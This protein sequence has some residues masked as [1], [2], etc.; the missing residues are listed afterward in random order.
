[1][2][3]KTTL[4]LIVLAAAGGGWFLY[5]DTR[6]GARPAAADSSESLRLVARDL[7]QDRLSRIEI[8]RANDRILFVHGNGWSLDGGWPARSAEVR[9][10][11]DIVSGV[12]T[13]FEPIELASNNDLGQ[14]GLLREQNPVQVIATVTGDDSKETTHSLLFGQP[15]GGDGNPFTRPTFLRID[16]QSEILRL[17]PGTKAILNRPRDTYLK[18]QLFP[19]VERVKFDLP[20][21]AFPGEGETAAPIILLLVAKKIAVAGPDGAWTIDR[22][23]PKPVSP[24]AGAAPELSAEKLASQ[25]DMA[26]PV[27]DR[28][29]PGVLKSI[30][31]AI[32][33]LWVEQFVD[34]ADL[35]KTGL[36][37]PGWTVAV[38]F[39]DRP[40]VKVLIGAVSRTIERRPPA[41][42]ANPLAP[43]PPQPPAVREEYRYAK[44]P[45]NPQIFEVKTERFAELFVSTA[46]LR[47]PRI[48][49]FDPQAVRRI[50]VV[51]PS[52]RFVMTKTDDKWR[53]IEPWTAD[54]DAARI[55]E[56][57]DRLSALQAAGPDILDKADLPALGLSPGPGVPHVTLTL[58]DK[59]KPDDVE[60]R[61]LWIGKQDDTKKKVAV[62]AA[63]N[64]RVDL[65]GDDFLR[66]FDRPAVAYRGRRVLDVPASNLA[67]IGIERNNNRWT[68]SETGGAWTLTAGTEAPADAAKSSQLSAELCRLEAVD[69]VTD[70]P[71]PDD[72]ARFGLES[73]KLSATLTFRDGAAAKTLLIGGPREGKPE[74]YARWADSPLIFTIRSG[75]RDM[76]DQQP[77]NFRPLLVWQLTPESITQLDVQT[78]NE[79]FRLAQT[80]S[81][82]ALTAP[83]AATAS[84]A[85]VQPLLAAAATI[86]AERYEVAKSDDLAHYGLAKPAVRVSVATGAVNKS[87]AIGNAVPG[88]RS[89]F[90]K[91]SD[92][93]AVF[94]VSDALALAADRPVLTLIDRVLLNVNG[95]LVTEISGASSDGEWTLRKSGDQWLI[96]SL[97]PPQTADHLTIADLLRT[98]ADVTATRFVEFGPRAQF[99]RFGLDRPTATVTVLQA[100]TTGGAPQSHTLAIGLQDRD[101]EGFYARA[102]QSPGIAEIPA[103]TAKQLTHGDLDFVSR[104]LL[105]LDPNQLVAIR[106]RGGEELELART[107]DGWSVAKPAG[108]NADRANLDSL[109]RQLARLRVSRVVALDAT[110]PAKY[111]FDSS[112]TIVALVLKSPEGA[113]SEKTIEIGRPVAPRYNEPDGSRYVRLAGSAVVGILP[114]TIGNL[115]TAEPFKLRDRTIARFSEADRAVMERGFRKSVFVRQDGAWKMTEPVAADAEQ[116]PL[117]DLVTAASRLRADEF[118]ADRPAD[119]RKYGLDAPEAR[120]RFIANDRDVLKL[121]VGVKEANGDRRYAKLDGSDT[122]FLLDPAMSNRLVAE[123]RQ[124]NAWTAVPPDQIET[125]VY[126]I[127]DKTLVLQKADG[128]WQVPGR[129]EQAVNAAAIDDLAATMANLR[130]ERF[131]VDKDP[132][133][134]AFGLLNPARTIVIR[135]RGGNPLTLYLGGY[136]PGSKRLYARVFDNARTDVFTLSET[137]SAKLLRD[138]RDLLAK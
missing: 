52:E 91:L 101:S 38:E 120:W 136:E 44:L 3:W 20:R 95:P 32:P 112:G 60:T 48:L 25:W 26:A 69:F 85:A 14:F 34:V 64:P 55:N 11:V 45:D 90:A 119:L 123:Y 57:I 19:D 72:L 22:K 31:S 15:Q 110:D 63:G 83:Y 105:T 121:A 10:V 50:E 68:L 127:G 41:P 53:I 108:F 29:D 13:R 130:V 59:G 135:A 99:D 138:L 8:V 96:T 84:T 86:R 65:I 35:A 18:R 92:Q 116:T 62:Q 40:P 131:V 115:L 113:T 39:D 42:P 97:Q 5:R 82:W 126:S 128:R 87:I 122:V 49:R 21:P 56:F 47:D 78:E 125:L 43:P 80:P 137:D 77:L 37:K 24:R 66:I 133:L 16:A 61:T 93:D 89:R 70:A 17:A 132:D 67:S 23:G 118:V 46:A 114:P 81:G 54:A 36:E 100:S 106:R 51:R 4:A 58:A 27:S 74:V 12:S 117:N 73:A 111:G 134:R 129:P 109:V 33:E 104:D 124:R 30:L 28:V 71:K 94:V 79:T 102:D 98:L 9:E 88:Q 75:L 103:A 107:A 76:L 1:M 7:R 2:S 6:G